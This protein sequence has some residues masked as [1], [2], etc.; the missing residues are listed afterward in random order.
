MQ[1]SK[2]SIASFDIVKRCA[3]THWEGLYQVSDRG[4]LRC[5]R[6]LPTSLVDSPERRERF[7][8]ALDTDAKVHSLQ[9]VP[10]L[11]Q[12]SASQMDVHGCQRSGSLVKT[13]AVRARREGKIP[14]QL[15]QR[16]SRNLRNTLM[17]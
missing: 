12:V 17:R 8:S 10:L 13:S 11:P 1:I 4:S 3:G 9:H 2:R 5:L 14:Q 16:Y 7:Q 15:F 6:V